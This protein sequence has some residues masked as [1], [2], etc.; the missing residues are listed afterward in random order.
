M[1]YVTTFENINIFRE[2]TL[3]TAFQ[4]SDHKKGKAFPESASL[5]RVFLKYTSW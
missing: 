1:T 2:S 3:K 4:F 5:D